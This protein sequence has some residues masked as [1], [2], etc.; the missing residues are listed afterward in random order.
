MNPTPQSLN[1][2]LLQAVL[3]YF[4][5]SLCTLPFMAHVWIGEI[6]VFAM[7][8]L[9][10]VSLAGW[11]VSVIL[12]PF[13]QWVGWSQGSFSPDYAMTRPWG[14]AIVYVLLGF[15]LLLWYWRRRFWFARHPKWIVW[16]L[17]LFVFDYLWTLAFRSTPGLS[18]F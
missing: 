16:P 14:L 2:R 3:I 11:I 9:P 15:F 5:A 6:P 12:L 4:V 17:A 7:I 18:I 13:V 8:Q 1:P 10:K